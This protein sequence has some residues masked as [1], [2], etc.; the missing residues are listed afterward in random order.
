MELA[1][2]VLDGLLYLQPYFRYT[3]LFIGLGILFAR[4][5]NVYVSYGA[6]LALCFIASF[7]IPG[8]A[9]VSSKFFL[10]GGMDFLYVL[11]YAL[12]F[13]KG[14]ALW[15]ASYIAGAFL[16]I[17]VVHSMLFRLY[18]LIGQKINSPLWYNVNIQKNILPFLAYLFMLFFFSCIA[19]IKEK[20]VRLQESKWIDRVL[21]LFPLVFV[22]LVRTSYQSSQMD[23]AQF[24]FSFMASVLAILLALLFVRQTQI[25]KQRATEKEKNLQSS[26]EAQKNYFEELKRGNQRARRQRHDM[27]HQLQIIGQMNKEGKGGDIDAYIAALTEKVQLGGSDIYLD[28]PLLDALLNQKLAFAKKCGV[29]IE[30]ALD[31]AHPIKMYTGDLAVAL[32]NALDNAVEALTE[33]KLPDEKKSISL[34]LKSKEHLVFLSVE[35]PIDVMPKEMNGKLRSNKRDKE[36]H[37]IGLESIEAIVQQYEG[38]FQVQYDEDRFI[39][40][41]SFAQ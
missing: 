26:I 12:V 11:L 30:M 39:L 33:S 28:D 22:I 35:N 10:L 36:N 27:L 25:Q 21:G 13:F 31:I 6:V 9:W 38:I 2:R 14:K 1:Q 24:A 20:S 23:H 15:K 41:C 8:N 37:G 17:H 19:Y 5:W 18:Q 4:R 32:G 16:L 34:S 3:L 29:G 40:R 7:L